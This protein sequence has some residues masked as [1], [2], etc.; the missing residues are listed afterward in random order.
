MTK[1]YTKH[2]LIMV[3]KHLP[4]IMHYRY[5]L[6]MSC[7]PN[8]NV[9]I[10][11]G[12]LKTQ[13]NLAC[14]TY[15]IVNWRMFCPANITKSKL[16]VILSHDTIYLFLAL[17]VYRGRLKT[18]TNLAYNLFYCKL[19]NVCPADFFYKFVVSE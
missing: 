19:E 3:S 7:V 5:L 15:F 9:A 4:N 2:S 1:N 8:G 13:T 10:Y 17:H 16:T 6:V 14:I 18:Q 11:R 12:R